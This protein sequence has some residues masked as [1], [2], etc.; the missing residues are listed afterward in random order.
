MEDEKDVW[1]IPVLLRHRG[2]CLDHDFIYERRFIDKKFFTVYLSKP[3]K[4][5]Y[6]FGYLFTRP[7]PLMETVCITRTVLA[8]RIRRYIFKK[9]LHIFQHL[10]LP[11]WIS[12]L[13]I[14]YV[15]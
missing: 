13:V 8:R 10:N 5:D 2:Q 12:K 1:I 4:F 7:H 9:K 15:F 11:K 3:L 14:E 6:L